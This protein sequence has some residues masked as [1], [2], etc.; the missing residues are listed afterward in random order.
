MTE[1]PLGGLGD[2]GGALSG[3]DMSALLQQAQ[4]MQEQMVAAQQELAETQLTGT[5][6]GGLV[7]ATV[8]G[9]G[10][11]VAIS[12]DPKAVDPDD[13]EML[14]D[15]VLAAIHDAMSKVQ[16]LSQQAMGGL[17][18]GGLGGLLG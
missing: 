13:V 18:L 12:I 6:G 2:L 3:L 9:S 5:A 10:E 14:E 16:E 7:T 4:A 15:L 1:N 11:V 8:T 17:D